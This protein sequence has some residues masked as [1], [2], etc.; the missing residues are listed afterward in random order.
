VPVLELVQVLEREPV[1]ALAERR[2]QPDCL[3][4]S[5]LIPM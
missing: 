3:A 5:P 1:L 4:V 2:R